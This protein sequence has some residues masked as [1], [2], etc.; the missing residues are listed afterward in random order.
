MTESSVVAETIFA[1][2]KCRGCRIPMTDP[3]YIDRIREMIHYKS[4][5]I[6]NARQLTV[7]PTVKSMGFELV[8]AP[9]DI[10]FKDH[11]LVVTQFY[12]Y[13][14]ELVE[15]VTGCDF[16]KAV[17]HEYRVGPVASPGKPGSY[18][19][20]AHADMTPFIEDAIDTPAGQHFGIFNVW[21]SVDMDRSIES[22]PLALCD[23]STIS[24]DEMVCSNGL[25]RTDPETKVVFYSLIHSNLHQWQYFPRMGPD[26]VI[27]FRQYD[28]RMSDPA[29]RVTFHTA[30]TDPSSRD[31]APLRTTVEARVLAVF[32]EPDRESETRRLKFQA[33][34]PSLDPFGHESVW[35][36]DPMVDWE[37]PNYIRT[38]YEL[39]GIEIK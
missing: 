10:D 30:F 29:Q 6:H 13:C 24:A 5:C 12:E 2:A 4:I 16:A 39:S 37:N 36:F 27:I 17:Q 28:S 8:K 21:R 3:Q 32:T 33:E 35:H 11:N 22:Y 38:E 7:A 15:A 31:D 18:A 34:V 25:R 20:A 26:E 9:I 23:P 14:E 1:K 19:P